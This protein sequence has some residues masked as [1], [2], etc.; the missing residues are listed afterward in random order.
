MISGASNSQRAALKATLFENLGPGVSVFVLACCLA[1]AAASRTNAANGEED[2]HASRFLR[3]VQGVMAGPETLRIE[4][5]KIAL[6]QLA[7]THTLEAELARTAALQS[8]DR[9]KLQGWARAVDQYASDLSYLIEEVD[10]GAMPVLAFTP[11]REVAITIDGRMI[12]L[13]HPRH[14]Q[15]ASLEQITLQEFCGRNACEAFTQEVGQP[16][17]VSGMAS[18]IKPV[19]KFSEDGRHCT[20]EGIR[21]HYSAA[22]SLADQRKHCANLIREIVNL[23]D[24]IAWQMQHSVFVQWEDVTIV[25]TPARPG[26]RVQLNDAGDSVLLALPLLASGELSFNS[27]AQWLRKRLQLGLTQASLELQAI[28][29]D[30]P[31]SAAHNQPG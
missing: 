23:H 18:G 8:S 26:Y 2:I 13:S 29:F 21:I 9:R 20:Y 5:A 7:M 31:K 6:T 14:N 30:S 24:E 25:P 1:W 11:H 15:Q 10:R 12:I 19:W 17:A 16:S 4:F 28:D 27:V 22:G 3:T